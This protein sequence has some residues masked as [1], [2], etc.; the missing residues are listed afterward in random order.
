MPT[1]GSG[2]YF[3]KININGGFVRVTYILNGWDNSP[4]IRIQIEEDNGHVRQG[5]E[6]PLS[7][8]GDVVGAIVAL[9]SSLKR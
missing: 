9:L 3:E 1:D 6:I 7:N 5:P 4:S 8:I 2:N